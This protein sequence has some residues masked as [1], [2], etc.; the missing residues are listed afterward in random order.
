MAQTTLQVE[1]TH[2]QAVNDAL[3]RE[4]K[5]LKEEK[6]D[7]AEEMN[8]I[9]DRKK[10]ELEE[11]LKDIARLRK[12]HSDYER[13]MTATIKKVQQ[14]LADALKAERNALLDKYYDLSTCECDLIGLYKYCKVYRVPEDVRRSVL[15]EDTREELTLSA[16]LEDDIRGGSVREFLEWM[17][18]PLPGLKAVIGNYDIAAHFYVQYKKGGI[19]L[20]LLKSY[21]KD[22]GVTG[23]YEFTKETLLTVTAVGTCLEYFITVLPLLGGVTSVDFL[24]IGRY[25][26]PEDRRTMIGGG[27]VGEFLTTVVDLLPEPKHV[28]GFYE[29]LDEYYLAYKA[30]DISHDVLR[31]VCCWIVTVWLPVGTSEELSAGVPLGDYCKV[32]LPLLPSV[33]RIFVRREVDNID[34]CATLPERITSLDVRLC[35]AIKDFTPLLAM[36][37]LRD[38]SSNK[39]TNASFKTIIGQLKNNGV[40]V[41][42]C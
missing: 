30:G 34:W 9:Y 21:C 11:A 29:Y 33:T 31:A 32:M 5:E 26:L 24:N 18:V 39:S 14:E 12:E 27:S 35:T 8:N 41:K 7:Y 42:E 36:K 40:S 37:G 10:S 38:V 15:A 23:R 16:T 17:V 4:I 2:L 6:R 19:P 20:P 13:E 1:N 3:K 25:T 28:E 22:Y